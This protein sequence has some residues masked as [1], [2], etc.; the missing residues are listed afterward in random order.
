MATIKI[1][2]EVDP[3]DVSKLETAIGSTDLHADLL[4][5]V[6]AAAEEYIAMYLGR[7]A[8]ATGSELRQLRLAL[9]AKH[10]YKTGLPDEETVAGLFQLTLPASR[11]L[12]R[13][14]LTRHRATLADALKAA[15]H[16]AI[17]GA[18]WD[19]ENLDI[20]IP[21]PSLAEAM[22]RVLA[23]AGSE[24]YPV[25]RKPDTVSTYTTKPKSYRLLCTEYGVTPK[26]KP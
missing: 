24:H 26:A 14:T 20:K 7:E 2:I 5:H 4:A 1:E 16:T 3:A 17:D 19:G 25:L 13:N 12:I 8:P 18:E 23:R 21:S 6:Q 11:T 15:G 10:V 22:N 9:L